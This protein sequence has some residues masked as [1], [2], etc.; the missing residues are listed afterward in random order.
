MSERTAAERTAPIRVAS[1]LTDWIESSGRMPF[2]LDSRRVAISLQ[3]N[4]FQPFVD[5]ADDA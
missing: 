1:G 5:A 2:R 4:V 3:H